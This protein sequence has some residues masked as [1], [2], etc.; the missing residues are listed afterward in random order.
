MGSSRA[1]FSCKLV[2]WLPPT[3]KETVPAPRLRRVRT[4]GQVECVILSGLQRSRGV[5]SL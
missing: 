3:M 1:A 4:T 5:Q 2:D